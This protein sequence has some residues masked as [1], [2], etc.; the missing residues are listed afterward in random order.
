MYPGISEVKKLRESLEEV[1][2]IHWINIVIQILGPD[3]GA[4]TL[5]LHKN[6]DPGTLTLVLQVNLLILPRALLATQP[7]QL[8]SLAITS[9]LGQGLVREAP[10]L[11]AGHT[12]HVEASW[13]S[14]WG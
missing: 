4:L 8:G 10:V 13:A 6:T 3:P 12:G 5:V 11:L 9:L 2:E 7:E 14:F 1:I